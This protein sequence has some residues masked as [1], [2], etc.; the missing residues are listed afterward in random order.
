MA[1]DGMDHRIDEIL[2]GIPLGRM[3]TPDDCAATT[4][5]LLRDEARYL[6]GVTIDI[7]GA[8]YFH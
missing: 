1:R 2:S 3:A 5:F 7:N 4:S 8:S 6:S